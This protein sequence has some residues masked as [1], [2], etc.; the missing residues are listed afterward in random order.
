MTLTT[1]ALL[2]P[3]PDDNP[4]DLLCP[5]YCDGTC[6]EWN[7]KPGNGHH[8]SGFQ[9]LELGGND[10]TVSTFRTDE[11]GTAGTHQIHV[12]DYSREVVL[13]APETRQ[14]AAVLLNAA[15]MAD[16]L[17]YGVLSI[18]AAQVRIH[19]EVSTPDGWQTVIGQMVFG[20]YVSVWTDDEAHDPDTSGWEYQPGDLV[21][22]RRRIH[23][24]TAIAFVEPIR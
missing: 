14:F 6:V 1:T 24:S 23:G 15:D 5:P 22:V 12:G 4:L 3:E 18:P 9:H 21:Q 11:G 10:W 7:D 17:P 16:P 20:D 13:D 8:T 19:D 2:C